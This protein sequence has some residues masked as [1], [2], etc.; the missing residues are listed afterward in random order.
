M[1]KFLCK[2]KEFVPQKK[3]ILQKR[4]LPYLLLFFLTAVVCCLYVLRLGVFGA[5]VDWISQHSVLPDYFRKQFYETGNLF[6][7]FALHLGGGQNIY[8]F[9][10]YGLYSPIVL[11]SYLLPFVKMADYL[12]AAQFFCL[13]SSVLLLHRWLQER[14][15]SK[16]IAFGVSLLFLLA[17]PMIFHSYNQIMFVNYM[18]FLCMGFLG[19]DRYFA[20]RNGTRKYTL[21][22]C[23][24]ILMI[25]TS[26]YFSIGGMTAL[27]LYGL[28]RY[29]EVREMRGEKVTLPGLL[30]EGFQFAIP[31][32]LAVLCCGFLLVPTALALVGRESNISATIPIRELLLPQISLDR[33]FYTP[34]GIGLPVFGVIALTALLFSRKYAER[35]LAW[36]CVVI[37]TVPVFA[38]LLNGGL[39]IRDKAMI[40]F[41]PLLCYVCASYVRNLSETEGFY[42]CLSE[43]ASR[44]VRRGMAVF[45]YLVPF[46][47]LVLERKKGDVEAYSPL[48]LL[49]AVLML[50]CFL[51]AGRVGKKGWKFLLCLPIVFLAVYGLILHT[52][53]KRVLN[54]DFYKEI[55]DEKP[56]ELLDEVLD[57]ERGLY[58]TEQLGTDEENAANLNRIQTMRQYVSSFY[59]SSYHPDYLKFRKDTLELEQPF[60]NF[61]MQ[62]AGSNPVFLDFMGVKYLLSK[63]EQVGYRCI[64]KS[65]EW[66]V[67]ENADAL[68]MIYATNRLLPEKTYQMLSFPCSQLILREYAIVKDQVLQESEGKR[69]DRRQSVWPKETEGVVSVLDN[70]DEREIDEKEMENLLSA[71]AAAES[72]LDIVEFEFPREIVTEKKESREIPIVAGKTRRKPDGENKG[73]RTLFLQFQVENQKPSQ[74]VAVWVEGVRNKLTAKS[75]VYYNGN[76]TFSY[77]VSLK[78]GQEEITVV[79][80]KGKYRISEVKGWI[81]TRE[82]SIS[83]ETKMDLVQSVFYPDQKRT[84]G[85][86]I[87]GEITVTHAGYIVTSIPYEESFHIFVDGKRVEGE[88]VNTAFLGFRIGEGKHRIE[89]CFHAPGACTGK[90]IS[91]AGILLTLGVY[92]YT[93][94]DA[95]R[96]RYFCPFCF[97]A[98]QSVLD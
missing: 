97:S 83:K 19:V 41:L 80:G 38:Y 81:Q 29:L 20:Q 14:G 33:F 49:D 67:Y 74:D 2:G 73:N 64:G 28:F 44:K 30:R 5:K 4:N 42:G 3:I 89:I 91:L 23:S 48:F 86:Q 6:P 11:F 34:Y 61:L 55:V 62:P 75:H 32:F 53:A 51:A 52:E 65:G 90:W 46:L 77:A 58:R 84:K 13:V 8:Y 93:L 21:L 82:D 76:T 17:G 31:F 27:I 60:R 24:V 96:H 63:E 16:E 35:I 88:K 12:M 92:G 45:P 69:N 9:A 39:Y 70:N 72:E 85:N 57:T 87:A 79:F 59:S 94:L 25:L 10:Y 68:P 37:L 7:E 43:G 95:K 50:L 78:E 26:F 56:G 22:L 47:L 1:K 66:K 18:P 15:F 98:S 40:P 71:A 54:R 36:G